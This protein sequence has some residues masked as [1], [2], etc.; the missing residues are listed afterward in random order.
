MDVLL[1]PQF[2]LR[3]MG[4]SFL[5][6]LLSGDNAL[7]IAL[8]VRALPKRKR[9]LGQI[10]G[11]A[12]AVPRIRRHHGVSSGSAKNRSATAV[13]APAIGRVTKIVRRPC[14]MMRLCRSAFSARSP[15]TRARTS[16]AS[17]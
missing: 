12:G 3:L 1:D 13:I 17:G 10:W 2:W 14:D 11:A 9:V 8:A 6:L 15:R 4:I 7:V 16:G 5:N